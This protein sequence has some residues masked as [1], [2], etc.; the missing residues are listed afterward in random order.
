MVAPHLVAGR[1]TGGALPCVF[2][3]GNHDLRGVCAER[4]AELTPTDCGKSYC[5]FRLGPVWG[6]VLDTGEDKPDDHPEYGGTVCCGEFRAEEELWLRQ[7]C[8]RGPPAGSAWR[9]VVCHNPFAFRLRPPFDIEQRRWKRWLR[10]LRALGPSAML[11]GHLHEC[12][13][14]DPGGPHDSLG[15]PCPVV[16]ASA[17]D[18][19]ARRFVCGAVAIGRDGRIDAAFVDQDGRRANASAGSIHGRIPAFKGTR[20][21]AAGTHEKK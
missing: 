2:A 18:R 19:K 15:A 7:V 11:C 21:R 5:E 6:V 9:L 3:R 1:A 12:F 17:I 14:E 10:L 20:P 16:C 4:Y 13:A 8:R